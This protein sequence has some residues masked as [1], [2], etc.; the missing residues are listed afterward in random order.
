MAASSNGVRTAP[1]TGVERGGADA[2]G[3]WPASSRSGE[4][5]VGE[6]IDGDG[7]PMG[8]ISNLLGELQALCAAMFCSDVQRREGV[9]GV[10]L[11]LEGVSSRCK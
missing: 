1:G 11:P 5:V 4:R 9:G 8:R 2:T 7:W 10:T 3:S 6:A